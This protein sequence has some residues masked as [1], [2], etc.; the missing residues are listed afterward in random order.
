[1]Y[2][3][4]PL[5]SLWAILMDT[6]VGAWVVVAMTVSVGLGK[7][8]VMGGIGR[9]HANPEILLMNLACEIYARCGNQ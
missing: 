7:D 3:V 8:M 6:Y 9:R 4:Y 5:S 2:A 1:M